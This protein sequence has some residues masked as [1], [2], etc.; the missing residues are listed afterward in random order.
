[1]PKLY[2]KPAG[3]LA[4][5]TPS[6]NLPFRM[7]AQMRFAH[8]GEN[9]PKLGALQPFCAAT[10]IDLQGFRPNMLAGTARQLQT[11][12]E[13][14]ELGTVDLS[15]VDYAVI[16]FTQCGEHP[17]TDVARVVLWQTF[18]GPVFE[19][20]LGPEHL[21]L[22]YECEL[23]E[24]WHIAPRVGVAELG[25]EIV[26]AAPGHDMLR[27]A[28]SGFVTQDPCPCGR[29]SMRLLNMQPIP[30]HRVSGPDSILRW[31][32]IA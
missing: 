17:L 30:G 31:A 4:I 11:L 1:M 22:G 2:L 10:V 19:I 13:Q 23:H 29:P 27:T 5:R 18:G 7:H 8:L 32:A 26:M 28:V 24:G 6:L 14:V 20:L 15:S 16:A 25:G 12:A 9:A 3:S 21:I